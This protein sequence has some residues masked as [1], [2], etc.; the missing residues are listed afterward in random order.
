MKSALAF[1]LSISIILALCILITSYIVI[2]VL[3]TSHWFNYREL[4]NYS[5]KGEIYM[6]SS[7]E[8]SVSEPLIYNDILFCDFGTG[9][10]RYSS[11]LSRSVAKSVPKGGKIVI[12]RYEGRVPKLKCVCYIESQ[13]DVY[14][15]FGIK[16]EQTIRSLPFIYQP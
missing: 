10:V 13:I 6:L 9:E 14:A 16:K 3:P 15:P 12:W 1:R 8:K 7:F 11:N 5:S 2:L 4:K